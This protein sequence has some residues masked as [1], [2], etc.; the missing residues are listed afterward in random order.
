MII[1]DSCKERG[2][3]VS[4][5]AWM[6]LKARNTKFIDPP[7]Q[8]PEGQNSSDLEGKGCDRKEEACSF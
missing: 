7:P 1:V 2:P 8:R 3:G 5:K 4:L 6:N